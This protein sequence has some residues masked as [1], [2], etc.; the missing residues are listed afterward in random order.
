MFIIGQYIVAHHFLFGSIRA[1]GSSRDWYEAAF[2]ILP[3]AFRSAF[4]SLYMDK[5]LIFFALLHER[6]SAVGHCGCAQT[7]QPI[8]VK[9][10]ALRLDII[11]AIA[12]FALAL[13]A[14]SLFLA[15]SHI[16]VDCATC[17]LYK[18]YG[19]RSNGRSVWELWL[20]SRENRNIQKVQMPRF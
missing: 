13:A 19:S 7:A 16:E 12:G 2:V 5:V 3:D 11:E 20:T 10:L 9:V 17:L 6:E 15:G 18:S 4:P 1:L 8:P 14:S